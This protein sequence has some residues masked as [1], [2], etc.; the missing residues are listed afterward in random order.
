L[1]TQYLKDHSL[2]DFY[3]NVLIPVLNMAERDRHHGVLDP[4]REKHVY[5]SIRDLIENLGE[6]RK[7]EA[8]AVAKS[9][10]AAANGEE[11]HGE[12]P[13][14][15]DATPTSNGFPKKCIVCLP[16]RDEADEIA[17]LML[18]Q[19]LEI[20]GSCAEVISTESLA[21]EVIEQIEQRSPESVC[22][23]AMPPL[24]VMHSRYLCKRLATRFQGLRVVVGLWH[25]TNIDRARERIRTCGTERV[26]S[27]LMQAVEQFRT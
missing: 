7:Q 27:T 1:A 4:T 5:Q 17:A 10:L 13:A 20:E 19:L 21:A 23:S 9:E 8:I 11:R 18:A 16:A 24:A 12:G 25:T 3:D 2:A 6:Q 26:V 15:L 14:R 22:I